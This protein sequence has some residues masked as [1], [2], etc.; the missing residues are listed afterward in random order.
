MLNCGAGNGQYLTM[1]PVGRVCGARQVSGADPA[2]VK[3]RTAA[4][5]LMNLSWFSAVFGQYGLGGAK[6]FASDA[7]F[8]DNFRVFT[9]PGPEADVH[10]NSNVAR[11]THRLLSLVWIMT[12]CAVLSAIGRQSR[13]RKEARRPCAAHPTRDRSLSRTGS[14]TR[15][16]CGSRRRPARC[17]S[18]VA[19]D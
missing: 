8:S 9:Q 16:R 6:K 10:A 17:S 3:T 7:P 13:A 2:R 14:P 1:E 19:S 4:P 18:A 15:A 5:R 12:A 11:E